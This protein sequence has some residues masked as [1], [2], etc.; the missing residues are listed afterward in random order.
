MKPSLTFSVTIILLGF[1]SHLRDD[2]LSVKRKSF[3]HRVYLQSQSYHNLEVSDPRACAW[4]ALRVAGRPRVHAG[5]HRARRS[6]D[7]IV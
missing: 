2:C 5:R 7:I 3:V 6:L 1:L 4:G